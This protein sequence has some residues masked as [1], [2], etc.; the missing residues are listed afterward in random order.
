MMTGKTYFE[1]DVDVDGA[2]RVDVA[3]VS[4]GIGEVDSA[5]FAATTLCDHG[6]LLNLAVEL[7]LGALPWTLRT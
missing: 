6:E 7:D 1:T 3:T 5:L 2:T 4:F